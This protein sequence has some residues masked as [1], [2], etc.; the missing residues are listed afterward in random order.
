MS[1]VRRAEGIYYCQLLQ[2]TAEAFVEGVNGT[3]GCRRALK[4]VS[5]SGGFCIKPVVAEGTWVLPPFL[6]PQGVP[7]QPGSMCRD[8]D[9]ACLLLPWADPNSCAAQLKSNKNLPH[10][11]LVQTVGI[12]AV[13]GRGGE[14]GRG[15]VVPLSTKGKR[16]GGVLTFFRISSCPAAAP[17]ACLPQWGR[18]EGEGW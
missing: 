8:E 6:L 12:L 2:S 1:N 9:P 13:A 11:W 10:S 16:G 5:P 18:E 3:S 14:N 17:E 15:G 7:H 4:R